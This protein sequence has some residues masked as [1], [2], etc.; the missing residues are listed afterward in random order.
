MSSVSDIQEQ[1]EE[2]YF[3]AVQEKER[4]EQLEAA[5]KRVQV[6]LDGKPRWFRCFW[7]GMAARQMQEIIDGI[8]EQDHAK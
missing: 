4:C 6:L 2:L 7:F 8:M 1:A 5:I 3:S